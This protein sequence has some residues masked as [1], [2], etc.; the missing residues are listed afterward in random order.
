MLSAD[1]SQQNYSFNTFFGLRT[2][3]YDRSIHFQQ[4][5]S[6][7]FIYVRAYDRI[8]WTILNA[9]NLDLKNLRTGLWLVLD[10]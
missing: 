10:K 6:V 4:V 1:M 8:L 9:I 2:A 7:K 3:I 5:L